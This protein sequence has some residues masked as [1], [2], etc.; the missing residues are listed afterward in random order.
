VALGEIASAV[1]DVMKACD[2]PVMVDGDN[3]Y[4]DVKNGVHVLHT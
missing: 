4:G 2:L 1:T 3:G